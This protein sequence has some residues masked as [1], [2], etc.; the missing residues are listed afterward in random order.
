[1]NAG[2]SCA[3][4]TSVRSLGTII[5]ILGLLASPS[6]SQTETPEA[7]STRQEILRSLQDLQRKYGVD[8]VMIEGNLLQHAI[9]GGSI[10]EAAVSIAGIEE[11]DGK[12][13]LAFKV[14][15]GIIYNDRAVSAPARP[16]RAWTD[17][18]ETTLRKLR[19][20]HIP[21]DGIVLTLGYTHK[22]YADEA[23]LR[24]HL[25]DGP[26]DPEAA[27][28]Y[29]LAADVAELAAERITGQ[30][31]VDRSTVLVNGQTS[32]IILD[33]PTPKPD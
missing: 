4:F 29:L 18:A 33:V 1:M 24:A 6:R 26:G 17:I 9:R 7:G 10:L 11:H 25:K 3:R 12:R 30:Q 23:D 22:P 21:A 13:F 28:F 31:L 32:R 19:T 2:R 8:A 14:D 27:V 16:A 5:V 15:T 20:M